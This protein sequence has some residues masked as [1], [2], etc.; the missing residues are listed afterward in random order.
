MLRRALSFRRALRA[1]RCGGAA[2]AGTNM[3]HAAS[4]IRAE[5]M[6]CAPRSYC[7]ACAHAAMLAARQRLCRATDLFAAAQTPYAM[8]LPRSLC[9]M[10][11]YVL[12][13][14]VIRAHI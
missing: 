14:A 5:I 4:V 3:I 7:D 10:P 11:P 12:L 9:A 6:L 8:L 13:C 1:Q 2:R